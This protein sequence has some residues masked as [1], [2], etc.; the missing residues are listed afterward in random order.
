MKFKKFNKCENCGKKT[1]NLHFVDSREICFICKQ[2][3][4]AKEGKLIQGICEKKYPLY[5]SISKWIVKKGEN[6]QDT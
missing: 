4:L 3:K 2:K 1:K 5:K 6:E